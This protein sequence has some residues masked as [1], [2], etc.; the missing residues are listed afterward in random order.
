M[1]ATTEFATREK[2][3]FRKLDLYNDAF[4][5]ELQGLGCATL[6]DCFEVVLA[7]NSLGVPCFRLKPK[8]EKLLPA[9]LQEIAQTLFKTCM[10]SY[11]F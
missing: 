10:G 7:H 3:F 9:A 2:Q 5:A 6:T 4:A 1:H 8:P 11:A